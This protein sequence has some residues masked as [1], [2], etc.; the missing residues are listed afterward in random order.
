M[1]WRRRAP[2]DSWASAGQ[3]MKGHDSSNSLQG[4]LA[5]SDVTLTSYGGIETILQAVRT[6]LGMDVAFVA[7]FRARDRIFRHVDAQGATPVNSGDA[8]PLEQGYCQRVVD[9][10]LPELI[11]DAQTLP[12]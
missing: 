5:K 4:L 7:E 12:E 2:R 3:H 9:G 11:V 1:H 6:H 8:V 10:R